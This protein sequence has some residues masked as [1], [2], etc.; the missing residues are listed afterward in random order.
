MHISRG[1]LLFCRARDQNNCTSHFPERLLCNGDLSPLL[2]RLAFVNI[3]RVQTKSSV[4]PC[5][6]HLLQCPLIRQTLRH[7]SHNIRMATLEGLLAVGSSHCLMQKKCLNR[8]PKEPEPA[9]LVWKKTLSRSSCSG[10]GLFLVRYHLNSPLIS[11]LD[12]SIPLDH[13]H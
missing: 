5:S 12:D 2:E 7:W 11:C 4:D 9:R 13:V 10:S 3:I 8:R 1:F 6:P